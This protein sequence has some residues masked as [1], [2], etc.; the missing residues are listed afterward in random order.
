ML[1]KLKSTDRIHFQNS[2]LGWFKKNKRNLPWRKETHW[3]PVFLSEVMLQQ[4][5]VEQALPYY[6]KFMDRFPDIYSLSQATE[7]EVLTLWAGLGYYSRARNMLKAAQIIVTDY[8]ARFPQDLKQALS[9]PGIGKYSASAI[10]S[11]VFKK[12]YAVVDGN[13][14]RVIARL[15]SI[16]DDIR[17]NKI[18]KA[19]QD[20]SDFLISTDNPGDYNEAIMELGAVIC[21]KQNPECSICPVQSFCEAFKTN[22]QIQFP[23]KSAASP[24]RKANHYVCIVEKN[25][26]YLLV[27]RP[28]SGLLASLW[29]FPVLEVKKI[30]LSKKRIEL[31]LN[32][33]YNLQGKV[34]L[35]GDIF[36]HQYSHIDLAYQPVLMKSETEN[37]KNL[38]SYIDSR[39][40]VLNALTEIPIHNAH[41]KLI[42]WLKNLNQ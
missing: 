17:L 1:S 16:S 26:K 33:T 4:T 23:Y 37:I 35:K 7:Q 28:A 36:R 14:Y 5:Q 20:I 11:I 27:Q 38:K 25:Q 30:N 40:C 6:L 3:Y 22:R 21:R 41:L 31:I 32:E 29:E 9:I 34:I 39:W 19:I 42:E 18:Q 8:D 15:F 2:L 12:P 13:V 10:L 24:K